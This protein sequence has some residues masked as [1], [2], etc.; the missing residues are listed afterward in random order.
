MNQLLKSASG[1]GT[2]GAVLKDEKMSPC[3]DIKMCREE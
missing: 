2:P 3:T 1:V